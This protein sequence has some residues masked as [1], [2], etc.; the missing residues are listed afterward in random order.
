MTQSPRSGF[1]VDDATGALVVSGGSDPWLDFLKPAGLIRET[2]PRYASPL[3][4]LANALTLGTPTCCALPL[5]AGEV[6]T[7][8]RWYVGSTG[9]AASSATNQWFFLADS[10]LKILAVTSDDT[11]A[12]WTAN[13]P[14]VLALTAPYSVT[15]TGLYYVGIVIAGGAATP[16]MVGISANN[17]SIFNQSPVTD[18]KSSTT[19]VTAPLAVATTL[20]A[21]SS[22]GTARPYGAVL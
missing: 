19:G 22:T 8:I 2:L 18:G 21:V 17:N 16:T 1:L 15:S 13:T 5:L 3:S 14:K 7:S 12:A 10:S 11:T 6:V 20:G 9:L 4:N